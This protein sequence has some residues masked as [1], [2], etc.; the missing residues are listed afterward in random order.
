MLIVTTQAN[1]ADLP[2]TPQR[3]DPWTPYLP[4]AAATA[5]AG[6]MAIYFAAE[7]RIVPLR[8]RMAYL[9]L[10]LLGTASAGLMGCVGVASGQKEL[11]SVTVTATSRGVSKTT[12]VIIRM[13]QPTRE[14]N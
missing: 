5:L 4:W 13:K 1:L 12:T 3:Q 11:S 10:V 6:L 7:H 2:L 14:M 8:G 9:T